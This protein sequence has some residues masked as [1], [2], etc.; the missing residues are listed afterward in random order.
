MNISSGVGRA[1]MTLGQVA[2]LVPG[3]IVHI[4]NPRKGTLSASDVP[5]LE[6]RFGVHDGRYAIEATSWLN[7]VTDAAA[8]TN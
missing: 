4:G 6:G 8:V 3:D 7:A 5:V 1:E 2:D